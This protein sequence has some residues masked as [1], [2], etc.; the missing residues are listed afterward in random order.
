MHTRT[1]ERTH[2]CTCT[3]KHYLLL[4]RNNWK[5]FNYSSIR[6]LLENFSIFLNGHDKDTSRFRKISE[7]YCR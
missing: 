3:Q 5:L 1:H 7:E 2:K 4:K 6:E